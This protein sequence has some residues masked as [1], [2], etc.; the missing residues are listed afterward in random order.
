[1]RAE[2]EQGQS[3]LQNRIDALQK[4]FHEAVAFYNDLIL[5]HHGNKSS[6][7]E[8]SA[9]LTAKTELHHAKQK[10]ILTL[11]HKIESIRTLQARTTA[12][13]NE[14]QNQIQKIEEEL[15]AGE[16]MR[17]NLEG[18]QIEKS[19]SL[20]ILNESLFELNEALTVLNETFDSFIA[21]SKTVNEEISLLERKADVA[22]NSIAHF[23]TKQI[24]DESTIT[25][26]ENE[27]KVLL[28]NDTL[29]D[30]EVLL[31]EQLDEKK[32]QLDELQEQVLTHKEKQ[33]ELNSQ[34]LLVEH[35]IHQ[36]LRKQSEFEGRL[37][38][39]TLLQNALLSQ[40]E[41]IEPFFEVMTIE[42]KWQKAAE[43]V[44]SKFL[45]LSI[46]ENSR[47]Y[48]LGESAFH[49]T[50]AHLGFYVKSE[51]KLGSLL[52]HVYVADS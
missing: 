5:K 33:S 25:K 1:K 15:V 38:A 26:L 28:D 47:G 29:K 30:R 24:T 13:H 14:L 3:E 49:F 6:L 41:N 51:H 2:L 17:E 12:D 40:E 4:E 52:S 48:V 36:N 50:P 43:A 31:A 20:M 44:L 11:Q 35:A 27:L 42:P 22:K 45:T 34:K 32:I 37:S 21:Q 9:L 7:G 23:E 18:E 16:M 19:E 46:R 39:L 8:K 10:E